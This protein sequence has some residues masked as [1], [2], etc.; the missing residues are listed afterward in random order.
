MAD[1]RR[2]LA[3]RLHS[4]RGDIVRELQ[5]PLE[6]AIS[7]ISFEQ[8]IDLQPYEN[9]LKV[10]ISGIKKEIGDWA[11]VY[12]PRQFGWSALGV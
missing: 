3:P 5:V 8:S 2:Q 4:Y 10:V 7:K 11:E 9:N 6:I 12:T 1:T